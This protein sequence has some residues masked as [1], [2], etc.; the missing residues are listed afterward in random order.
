M[1]RKSDVAA[2]LKADRLLAAGGEWLDGGEPDEATAAED[3][4]VSSAALR[5]SPAEK[6]CE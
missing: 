3:G 1:E 2:A 6:E 5:A 4:K